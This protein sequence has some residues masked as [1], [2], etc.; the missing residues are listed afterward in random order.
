[1]KHGAGGIEARR[2]GNGGFTLVELLVVI[3][4]TSLLIALILPV[5]TQGRELARQAQCASNLRQIGL[6]RIIYAEDYNGRVKGWRVQWHDSIHPYMGYSDYATMREET[7]CPSREL[8][9]FYYGTSHNMQW[10]P[11]IHKTQ[12]QK[13]APAHRLLNGENGLRPGRPWADNTI[14]SRSTSGVAPN[15]S[16][17]YQHTGD[18]ANVIFLDLHVQAMQDVE[19]PAW[20]H[21]E[22]LW[23]GRRAPYLSSLFWSEDAYP[24]VN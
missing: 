21:L 17:W 11:D 7:V 10:Y 16:L 18:R 12:A 2:C 1:M 6:A 22:V 14:V 15:S 24:W 23:M 9:R 13:G 20:R 8:I 19:V 5:I 3:A 4:I